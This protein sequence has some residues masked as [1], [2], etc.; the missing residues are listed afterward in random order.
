MIARLSAIDFSFEVGHLG[1]P[2]LHVLVAGGHLAVHLALHGGGGLLLH[3]LV[4]LNHALLGAGRQLVVLRLELGYLAGGIGGAGIAIG[5]VVGG[6]W[7]V[8]GVAGG[9]ATG[10]AAVAGVG[11][12]VEDAD[13][14]ESEKDFREKGNSTAY[15]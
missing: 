5:S 4:D 7:T 14:E 6:A 10:T 1:S 3:G 8:A 12:V 2:C 13:G 9:V 15:T 11:C